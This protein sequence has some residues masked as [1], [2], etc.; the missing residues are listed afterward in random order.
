MYTYIPYTHTHTYT[1]ILTHTI[2]MLYIHTHTYTQIHNIHTIYTYIHIH[3]HTHT[4]SYTHC[5][6]IPHTQIHIL[7]TF[8]ICTHIYHIHTIYAQTIHIHI[9]HTHTHTHTHTLH[10]PNS[11]II[12]CVALSTHWSKIL[13]KSK[14]PLGQS[15][16]S[17]FRKDLFLLF[18]LSTGW[19]AGA[20]WKITFR[21]AFLGKLQDHGWSRS[22]LD[23]DSHRIQHDRG[24]ME[25]ADPSVPEG[26]GGGFWHIGI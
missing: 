17:F 23:D 16:K 10:L 9:V 14:H 3:S 1:H 2:Y 4:I 12:E 21:W 13:Q 19:M 5:I 22:C 26:E 11:E 20:G 6:H 8:Y 7:Y 25:G 24:L 15:R 18:H